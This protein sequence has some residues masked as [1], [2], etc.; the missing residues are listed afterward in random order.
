MRG[1]V[2]AQHADLVKDSD[3]KVVPL[4]KRLEV[5]IQP[6]ALRDLENDG[7]L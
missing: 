2:A 6:E 1:F 5:M 4:R 7:L 3:P